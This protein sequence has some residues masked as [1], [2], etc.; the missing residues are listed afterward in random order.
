MSK[1]RDAGTVVSFDPNIR[2]KLWSSMDE[3]R[4]VIPAMLALTDI[5]LPSFDDEAMVWGDASPA[6]TLARLRAAGVA[7]VVVKNGAGAVTF[8][9]SAGDQVLTTPPVDEVLDTTGAGDGFNAGYLAA[10][11]VG[12]TPA[13]A[14][15]A[16]QRLS[17]EV[18]R[19]YGAR[20][21]KAVARSDPFRA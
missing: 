2:P 21:P 12:K 13:D 6:A 8:G 4:L 7:E 5:A 18:I 14:V 3:V 15:P 17:A 9:D 19:H 10:R 20:I 16:A 11:L 1:A